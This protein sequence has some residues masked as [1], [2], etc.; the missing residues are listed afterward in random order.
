MKYSYVSPGFFNFSVVAFGPFFF[1]LMKVHLFIY[2]FILTTLGL[3][4][5]VL[6]LSLAV[7]STGYFLGSV[8]RLRIAVVSL[9]T[10]HGL[11][12]C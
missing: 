8:R 4:L 6:G 10:E 1:F 2:L 12:G 11:R 3:P 7:V 5:A 9:A